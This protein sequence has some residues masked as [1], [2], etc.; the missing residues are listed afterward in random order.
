M[1]ITFP[2]IRRTEH[3]G[4]NHLTSIDFVSSRISVSRFL[5][6]YNMADMTTSFNREKCNANFKDGKNMKKS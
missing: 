2:I 3:L 5:I 1:K 4:I 6:Y